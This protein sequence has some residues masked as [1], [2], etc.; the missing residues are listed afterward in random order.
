MDYNQELNP[1]EEV[2]PGIY[3]M[4]TEFWVDRESDYP[5]PTVWDHID[6]KFER[7]GIWISSKCLKEFRVAPSL[8]TVVPDPILYGTLQVE[9]FNFIESRSQETIP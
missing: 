3:G 9:W 4:L 8:I 1:Y 6:Y 5:D 2:A 7:A